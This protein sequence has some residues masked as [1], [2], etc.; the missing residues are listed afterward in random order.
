[1]NMKAAIPLG[2]IVAIRKI[3]PR[4]TVEMPVTELRAMLLVDEAIGRRDDVY[5]R[6]TIQME[7]V[8][9]RSS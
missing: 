6:P 2:R 5:R 4:P 7:A 8:S 3:M 9:T 1:M